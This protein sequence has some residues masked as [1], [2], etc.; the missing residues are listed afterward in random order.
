MTWRRDVKYFRNEGEEARFKKGASVGGRS[1]GR[2]NGL[3]EMALE[4]RDAAPEQF[5]IRAQLRAWTDELI[6]TW[7]LGRIAQEYGQALALGDCL[8]SQWTEAACLEAWLENLDSN[9]D[10]VLDLFRRVYGAR[11]AKR[12]LRRWRIFFMACAELFAYRDG[13]EWRVSHYLF[14]R[15]TWT[16]QDRPSSSVAASDSTPAATTGR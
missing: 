12:W 1:R 11:E 8:A 10:D 16:T 6:A 5:Y 3:S 9:R 2:T 14:E 13:S 15:E 7:M 4:D